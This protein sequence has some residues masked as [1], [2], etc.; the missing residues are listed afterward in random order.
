MMHEI[1]QLDI[2]NRQDITAHLAPRVSYSKE[3]GEATITHT[4]F[5][6]AKVR[7]TRK[8]DNLRRALWWALLVVV[9]AAA[10]Q[11]WLVFHPAEPLP[12]ADS[13]SPVD[14]PEQQTRKPPQHVPAPQPEIIA[15]PAAVPVQESK[16]VTP[17]ATEVAKPAIIQKSA[18]Q[19]AP[20]LHATGPIPAKPVVAP[21]PVLANQPMTAVKPQ[22]APLA[23]GSVSALNQ[24]G[25]PL[26]AKP[27][28][29]SQPV[30]PAA[31][32]PHAALPAAHP[33]ASSPA[34]A[35]PL[36]S[37]V[38]EATPTQAPAGVQKT[39]EPVSVPGK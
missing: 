23:A 22:S 17:P 15:T 39:A 9:A 13:L 3:I 20:S 21:K 24:P 35:A 27:A 11:A 33:A 16:P 10:W 37:P 5:G 26:P 8:Y 7:I 31:V 34:A 29:M 1:S 38:R 12:S 25:K 6:R 36:A 28:P 14:E 2:P 4:I 18:P 19:P 32:L 30:A